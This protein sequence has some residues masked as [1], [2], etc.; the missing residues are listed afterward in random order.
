VCLGG[1]V[2]EELIYGADRVTSGVANV[3]P[4]PFPHLPTGHEILTPS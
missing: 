4:L 3:S 1:K 2:A